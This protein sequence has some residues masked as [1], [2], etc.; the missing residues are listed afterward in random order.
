M[1]L[2]NYKTAGYTFKC[3]I[4][5]KTIYRGENYAEVDGLKVSI[6]GVNLIEKEV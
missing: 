2:I 1:D 6:E 3:P 5:G 4:T